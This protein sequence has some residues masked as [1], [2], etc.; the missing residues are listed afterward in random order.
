[1]KLKLT[2]RLFSNSFPYY[3]ISFFI[4]VV[5][6]VSRLNFNGLVY[7]F[8]YGIFQPDGFYYS[9]QTLTYMGRE[10]FSAA[11]EVNNWYAHYSAK[12]WGGG[13][14][15]TLPEFSPL[16]GLV[17]PRILYPLLSVPF[18]ALFGLTGM[19]AIPIISLVTLVLAI[20]YLSIKNLIPYIGVVIN[21]LI[22]SSPTVLRWMISNITDSLL[23]GLFAL[24]AILIW[25]INQENT[26]TR[27]VSL[28]ALIVLTGL[29][30]FS[31][32]V[33]L[34][35]GLVFFINKNRRV[36][37]LIFLSSILIAIPTLFMGPHIAF[38]PEIGES[39]VASK[40]FA[41]P[42]K[43][44]AIPSIELLQLGALDRVLLGLVLLSLFLSI[45]EFRNPISQFYIAILVAL[46]GIGILNG[47][48]GVNFRYQL[49]L[50]PFS[51]WVIINWARNFKVSRGVNV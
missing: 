34:A 6:V 23:C 9:Y 38:L 5:A 46:L 42:A 27:S 2:S 47:T 7:G 26:N 10:H 36:A 39:S 18:V 25:K 48:L 14:V 28:V 50:I 17:A 3:L 40:L 49:P 41:L 8:D 22:L 33:W 19:F 43:L 11:T 13:P 44:I 31:L 35:I 30:R 37:L 15:E 51:A 20:Q 1:M 12:P 16:W 24:V 32:P 21:F 4:C 45:K 29:T